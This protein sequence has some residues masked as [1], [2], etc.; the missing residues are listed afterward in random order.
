[1]C[2]QIPRKV[3]TFAD[4][5]EFLEVDEENE[6]NSLNDSDILDNK[7]EKRVTPNNSDENSSQECPQQLEDYNKCDSRGDCAD[8]TLINT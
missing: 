4:F 1:V 3:V 2:H 7:Y 8:E 5:E 6:G